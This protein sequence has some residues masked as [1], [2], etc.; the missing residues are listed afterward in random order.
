VEQLKDEVAYIG[1]EVG[2]DKDVKY[3]KV[4]SGK[5]NH[6]KPSFASSDEI[7]DTLKEYDLKNPHRH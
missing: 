6:R 5:V 3:I 1:P 7:I 2:S 4:L